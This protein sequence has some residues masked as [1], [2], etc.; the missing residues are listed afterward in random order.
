MKDDHT[1]NLTTS[2]IHFSL[3]G[4]ENVF[5]ELGSEK[6]KAGYTPSFFADA[7]EPILLS[8]PDSALFSLL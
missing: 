3:K 5:F 4:R 2:L 7:W 8:A 1:T 6:D